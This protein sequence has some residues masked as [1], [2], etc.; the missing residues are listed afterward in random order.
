MTKRQT[1]SPL[2]RLH[3][4]VIYLFINPKTNSLVL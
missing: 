1:V 2:I 4:Y 3:I